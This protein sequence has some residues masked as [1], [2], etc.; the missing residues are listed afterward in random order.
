MICASLFRIALTCVRCGKPSCAQ[1]SGLLYELEYSSKGEPNT[2]ECFR[3]PA[4]GKMFK[5]DLL[6]L[7]A[8]INNAAKHINDDIGK[9]AWAPSQSAITQETSKLGIGNMQRLEWMRKVAESYVDESA[10]LAHE[11]AIINPETPAVEQISWSTGALRFWWDRAAALFVHGGPI[12]M[13]A[14]PLRHWLGLGGGPSACTW[15]TACTCASC[16]ANA[17]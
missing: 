16:S 14:W 17:S 6:H 7:A 11:S 5:P 2:N 15:P 3:D 9:N 12:V 13:L 10:W 8:K 1:D 4:P